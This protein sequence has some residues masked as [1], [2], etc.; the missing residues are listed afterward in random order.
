MSPSRRNWSAENSSGGPSRPVVMAS[1]PEDSIGQTVACGRRLLGAERRDPGAAPLVVAEQQVG[2]LHRLDDLRGAGVHDRAGESGGHRHRQEHRAE[3]VPARHAE[4][5]V[6]R[7]AR[8][9][10]AELVLDPAHRLEERQ[11]VVAVRADRHGQRVDD[12][13]LDRDA[14]L[15][16]GHLDD[17][18]D[19]H[20]PLVG[21]HRDLVLVVG[22]RDD[23]GVEALDQRQDRLHPLV[24][25]GHRVDQG[26]ALVD[27]QPGLERL[28][29]RGVDA[30]RQ[31]GEL[32]HHRDRLG[33]Q[34]R[35]VGQRARPC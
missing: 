28:D 8:H 6:G 13:V 22:Q 30:D 11:R 20:E 29:D 14:V 2:R 33:E 4:R 5:H 16:R 18:A 15:L 19:E 25:G 9:V 27:R 34:L 12:D 21:L 31:V 7:A 35:L 32:L 26:A 17:L 10:H 23:R 3:G 24:L 1:P